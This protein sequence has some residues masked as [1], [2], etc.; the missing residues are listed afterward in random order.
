MKLKNRY[1][2]LN[3]TPSKLWLVALMTF[4]SA[5]S[6][7]STES[8]SEAEF[9]ILQDHIQLQGVDAEATLS[10]WLSSLSTSLI[11]KAGWCNDSK[12]LNRPNQA[13]NCMRKKMKKL[14]IQ[15]ERRGISDPVIRQGILRQKKSFRMDQGEFS[16]AQPKKR[17]EPT[18]KQTERRANRAQRRMSRILRKG[19]APMPGMMAYLNAKEEFR[20]QRLSAGAEA[21]I[22]PELTAVFKKAYPRKIDGAGRVPLEASMLARFNRAQIEALSRLTLQAD[23]MMKSL[24][25]EVVY[26][27]EDFKQ[28]MMDIRYL[29]LEVEDMTSELLLALEEKEAQ[30]AE[31]QD[32]EDSD[33]TEN[34]EDPDEALAAQP[35]QISEAQQLLAEKIHELDLKRAELAASNSEVA[36]QDSRKSRQELLKQLASADP[37]DLAAMADLR[38]QIEDLDEVIAVQEAAVA[39]NKTVVHLTPADADSLTMNYIQANLVRMGREFG[40]QTPD[41]GDILGAVALRGDLPSSTLLKMVTFEG[42]QETHVTQLQKAGSLGLNLG[43]MILMTTPATAPYMTIGTL[44]WQ[45]YQGMKKARKAEADRIRYVR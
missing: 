31:S 42:M 1:Q 2:R 8:F 20:Q 3:R 11:E 6:I 9:Q 40:G 28:L 45:S 41:L 14:M 27:R 21:E 44:L 36:V 19:K 34:D 43:K 4:A 23:Q 22:A 10:D 16:I 18:L 37:K 39:K 26:Y 17:R 7:A 38:D 25:T 35:D 24:K 30:Q 15:A 12:L 13:A 29:E 5:P 33:E 32:Q